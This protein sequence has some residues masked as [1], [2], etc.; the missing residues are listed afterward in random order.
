MWDG[1]FE[2]CLPLIRLANV[3]TYQCVLTAL[4]RH[5]VRLFKASPAEHIRWQLICP[6]ADPTMANMMSVVLMHQQHLH[7]H[8][9]HLTITM[10]ADAVGALCIG[11]P[12]AQQAHF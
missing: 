10:P 1:G 6:D 7:S 9:Q 8:A 12:C 4:V 5:L 3:H 11:A 2:G